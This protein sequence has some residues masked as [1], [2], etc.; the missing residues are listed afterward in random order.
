MFLQKK[1]T[2]LQA[3]RLF[4]DRT[5]PQQVFWDTY[6]KVKEK[7]GND[8]RVH[9]LSY[10]GFGGIGKT[11]L[12]N[13]LCLD[14]R[15]DSA[16]H[17]VLFDFENAQD[18]RDVL[19]SLKNL[20]EAEYSGKFA[21]PLFDLGVYLHSLKLGMKANSPEA[22]KL[23]DNLFLNTVI[24]FLNF[25]PGVSVITSVISALDQ[26]Q[27]GIGT[28]LKNHRQELDTLENL[29]AGEL[30]RYLPLLFAEDLS[31][32]LENA[33]EPLVIFFDTYERLVNVLSPIGMPLESD[34]WIRGPEGLIQNIPGVLWVISG[35]EKLRWDVLDRAWEDGVDQHMLGVLSLLDSNWFLDQSGI[36]DGE[37]RYQLYE[38]TGGTPMY[39][40][41]CVEHYHQCIDHGIEPVIS[42]FGNNTQKLIERFVRYMDDSQ[43]S[44]V[45]LLAFV[46]RWDDALI[47]RIG[48]KVFRFDFALPYKKAKS[49]SF[50]LQSDDGSYYI[51][52]TVGEVLRDS[53]DDLFT[54]LRIATAKEL[55]EYY[56]Q[57]LKEQNV[58]SPGYA[59]LVQYLLQA[60][61]LLHRDR[62]SLIEF[63]TQKVMRPLADLG[64][65][66]QHDRANAIFDI[67]WDRAAKRKDDLLYA[68]ALQ[69]WAY[70][71]YRQKREQ[72]R[73]EEMAAEAVARHT[74][75]LG[76]DDPRITDAKLV[77]AFLM[78]RKGL[79]KEA[80]Q[81]EEAVLALRRNHYPEDH[82]RILVVMF[83]ISITLCDLREYQRAV[84]LA[85]KVYTIRKDKLGEDA[86]G[87]IQALG[88]LASAKAGLGEQEDALM[89]R[90]EAYQK[91]LDSLGPEDPKTLAAEEGLSVSLHQMKRD[92]EALIHDRYLYKTWLDK[93]GPDHSNTLRNAHAMAS[94]LEALKFYD[95]ALPIREDL[96]QRYSNAENRDEMQIAK[97][98][99]L[100]AE[101][102]CKL[103]M[104]SNAK[105]LWADLYTF[106]RNTLGDNHHSTIYAMDKLAQTLTDLNLI[107]KA[108]PLLEQ[109]YDRRRAV[110]GQNNIDTLFALS[111]LSTALM[112]VQNYPASMTYWKELYRTVVD[113]A[114]PDSNNALHALVNMHICAM[115]LD[116]QEESIYYAS[117]LYFNCRKR[118]GEAHDK[119]EFARSLYRDALLKYREYETGIELFRQVY[120]WYAETL[121]IQHD[122]TPQAL[123]D[124]T[125]FMLRL[126][127]EED[128]LDLLWK[129]LKDF[130]ANEYYNG[131]TA[132]KIARHLQQV[133]WD[134]GWEE[135][136]EKVNPYLVKKEESVFD[137]IDFTNLDSQ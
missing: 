30:K 81:I 109:L 29:E 132:L 64:A 42:E 68:F 124:L 36:G 31:H 78:H 107:S 3:T 26:L 49:L 12:L 115:C 108:I 122:S 25:I 18:S 33:K 24:P 110:Y 51:H 130:T 50:I 92:M 9:V 136:A 19:I 67:F 1:R 90:Q 120:D 76:E 21:F 52:K 40:D 119:T 83:N 8:D 43:K 93:L 77:Q 121:G 60:G 15:K 137:C 20:I 98:Q 127:M 104:Y 125:D 114:G 80:L 97:H 73:A 63:F 102:L 103:R 23:T 133:L 70:L 128:A 45:Y 129:L 106:Y 65:Y 59:N 44:I 88:Q 100:Y 32:N 117:E 135:E 82:E 66:G 46:E 94:D 39:L 4:T 112:D 6:R 123:I 47:E 56:S 54:D 126:G 91:C 131:D 116:Q 62:E 87:T 34:L 10:Y 17:H 57:T 86:P 14:L 113:L 74:L 75:L 27:S 99:G 96:F 89:M 71:L 84:E 13:Q 2:P 7:L 37:L 55:V 5:E 38:L 35:R 101:V 28:Y 69:E 134:L 72:E 111:R 53:Q 85:E 58:F 22:K 105:P 41:I 48:S 16:T 95:E 11:S 118:F 61:M 79:H